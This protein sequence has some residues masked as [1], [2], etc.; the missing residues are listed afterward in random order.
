[1][2]ALYRDSV[3][4]A[5]EPLFDSLQV[6][7]SLTWVFLRQEGPSFVL[8]PGL[9]IWKHHLGMRFF[10]CSLFRFK[11]TNNESPSWWVVTQMGVSCFGEGNQPFH[12]VSPFNRAHTHSN[13]RGEP[14]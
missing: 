5:G 6:F 13:V 10:E 4:Q 14:P 2:N 12:C 8:V 11:D 7:G 3:V 1:M 9:R